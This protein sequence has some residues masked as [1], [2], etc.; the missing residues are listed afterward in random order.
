MM[1]LLSLDARLRAQD[2]D[3]DGA[4][5]SGLC[6]LS[7][8]RSIG[9]EPTLL[10]QLVRMA[11]EGSAVD[12][13]ERILAQGQGSASSLAN[14]Q[15]E[16]ED[17]V[18]QPLFL[19]GLRGERAGHHRMISAIESGELRVSSM[20]AILGPKGKLESWWED[21]SGQREFR[22]SHGPLIRVMT[23]VVEIAKLPVEDQRPNLRSYGRSIDEQAAHGEIPVYIRLVVPSMIRVGESF[24]RHQALLRCAIVALAVERFRLAHGQWPDSLDPL[25]PDLITKIP[26]DPYDAKP[27]RYHRLKDGVVIYSIGPDEKDDG[28]TLDRQDPKKPGTDI[29]FQL[30]DVKSRRQPWRPPAKKT[31]PSDD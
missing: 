22:R 18:S 14:V 4:L 19:F 25:V 3:I 20:T 17:E 8:G 21:V 31:V 12:T 6:I 28:G 1:N 10:S 27:L 24:C 5:T 2:G 16:F 29:G 7:A 13:L 9:D 30:W 11:G 26:V 15:R 23:A